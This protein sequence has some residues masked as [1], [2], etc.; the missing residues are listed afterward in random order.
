MGRVLPYSVGYILLFAYS[1]GLADVGGGL[2]AIPS[3]FSTFVCEK[4]LGAHAGKFCIPPAE[5][6]MHLRHIY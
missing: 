1:L 2:L 6:L 5:N 3:T 4:K